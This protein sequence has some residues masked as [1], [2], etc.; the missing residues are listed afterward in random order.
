VC[1]SG[2]EFGSLVL[3]SGDYWKNDEIRAPIVNF[4]SM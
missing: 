1:E 2:R 4:S 3:E